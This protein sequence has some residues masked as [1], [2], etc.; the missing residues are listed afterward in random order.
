[1]E[2]FMRN[3][4]SISEEEQQRC[5]ALMAPERRERM[6]AL[7][8]EQ[9]RLA[10]ILGE[11]MAKTALA[12]RGGQPPESIMLQR[13]EK[14]KPFAQGLPCFNISHSGDWVAIALDEQPIGIDIE[15]LRPIDL[16]LARRLCTERDLAYLFEGAPLY[17]KTGDPALIRRFFEIWTAK[18][19]YFKCIGTG[20]TDLK[21]ISYAAL[22]PLHFYRNNCIIT[23]IKKA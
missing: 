18:E 12:E 5:L 6:Q 21:S 1:M 8:H 20:I 13:T 15:V 10:S 17:E 4:R 9:S 11:W 16:K 22:T 19:A 3:I 23:I 2:W 7:R 14:G